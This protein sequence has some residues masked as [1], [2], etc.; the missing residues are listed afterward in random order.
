MGWRARR[1]QRC[2]EELIIDNDGRNVK[3]TSEENWWHGGGDVVAITEEESGG[4]A[5]QTEKRNSDKCFAKRVTCTSEEV[6]CCGRLCEQC[7]D[8]RLLMCQVMS[9]SSLRICRISQ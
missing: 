3:G 9:K 2:A 6:V 1:W 5:W 8:K 4:T 7:Q